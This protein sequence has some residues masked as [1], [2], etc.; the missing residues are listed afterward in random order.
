MGRLIKLKKWLDLY[1]AASYLSEAFKEAVSASDVLRFSLDSDLVLS[2]N[3]VNGGY[4]SPCIP[5]DIENV[6]W[7]E[8]P[9]LTGDRVIRIPRKGRVWQDEEGCFQVTKEVVELGKTL[10][11][12]PMKGG[13]RIDVEHKYHQITFG[14]EKT[15]VSLDGVFVRDSSGVLYEVQERFKGGREVSS[16]KPFFS[17]DCFHPAGALPE[18]SEFVVRMC[19]LDEFI[20]NINGSNEQVAKPLGSRERDTLLTII[21]ALCTEAKIPYD[22]PAKA[23]GMIQSTAATMGVSIGETTIEGHLKKIPD[24]LA[25]RMK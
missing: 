13:E 6:E 23:A 3:L 22:K 21:A 15:S 8:V 18:D 20:L 1:E 16:G 25:T 9:A 10:W 14:P 24:A 12:L 4:G 7:D 5:V 11:D 2:V 19:A 17:P